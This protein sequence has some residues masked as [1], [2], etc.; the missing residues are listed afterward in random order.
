MLS[1]RAIRFVDEAITDRRN[2][3][4]SA[5]DDG[6]PRDLPAW[7]WLIISGALLSAFIFGY[8]LGRVVL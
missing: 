2:W 7:L 6:R 3:R 5:K 4:A 1:R 8:V